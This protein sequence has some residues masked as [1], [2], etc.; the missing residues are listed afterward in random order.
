MFNTYIKVFYFQNLSLIWQT[1]SYLNAY[2][3][4]LNMTV[5]NWYAMC[6][7]KPFKIYCCHK[8][9]WPKS[10]QT[11]DILHTNCVDFYLCKKWLPQSQFLHSG[12]VS[13]QETVFLFC[14]NIAYICLK[15]SKKNCISN[16]RV[17]IESIF[18]VL[19][20]LKL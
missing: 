7:C 15:E 19:R 11:P 8:C 14:K 9:C 2:S 5:C 10:L 1:L 18:R 17:S 4:L 20:F 6:E 12:C 13:E 16:L 3:D